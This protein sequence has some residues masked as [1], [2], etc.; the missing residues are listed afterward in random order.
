MGS[1]ADDKLEEVDEDRGVAKGREVHGGHGGL[2]DQVHHPREEERLERD[3]GAGPDA[4]VGKEGLKGVDRGNHA[5]VLRDNV[6]PDQTAER[7]ERSVVDQ[8]GLDG[9]AHHGGQDLVPCQR[10]HVAEVGGR[11]FQ[12][13]DQ[14]R[15]AGKEFVAGHCSPHQLEDHRDATHRLEGCGEGAGRVGAGVS[16]EAADRAVTHAHGRGRGQRGTLQLVVEGR[17]G[18]RRV[19]IRVED[20]DGRDETPRRCPDVRGQVEE[21]GGGDQ[22][23]PPR[24]G[25]D[26]GG[27]VQIGLCAKGKH[28]VGGSECGEGGLGKVEVGGPLEK[29]IRARAARGGDDARAVDD[30]RGIVSQSTGAGRAL[31][32]AVGQA[33]DGGSRGGSNGDRVGGGGG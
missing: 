4:R 27:E 18:P 17:L 28:N 24:R 2:G 14:E 31:D 19:C 13:L 30:G 21:V 1:W 22:G 12:Q 20:D 10:G 9:R 8:A 25:R 32:D 5:V 3:G 33:G 16:H 11:V 29:H 26:L 6:F 15:D 7:V 23:V